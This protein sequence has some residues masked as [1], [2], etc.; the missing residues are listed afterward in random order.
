MPTRSPT[1]SDDRTLDTGCLPCVLGTRA[2][3]RHCDGSSQPAGSPPP[4][5]VWCAMFRTST[6][7]SASGMSL[8]AA[9]PNRTL[10][11]TPMLASRRTLPSGAPERSRNNASSSASKGWSRCAWSWASLSGPGWS[12]SAPSTSRLRKWNSRIA[13]VAQRQPDQLVHETK[14]CRVVGAGLRDIVQVCHRPVH[15]EMEL[16]QDVRLAREVVVQRRLGDAQWR[17]DLA[18]RGGGVPLADEQVECDLED[19]LAGGRCSARQARQA[20]STGGAAVASCARSP[21]AAA[22]V[23][24]LVAVFLAITGS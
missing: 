15:L 11:T 13:T 19:P 14:P 16:Q 22:V 23:C 1:G 9:D 7:S 18:H 24:L 2:G 8:T 6:S 4:R 17:R 3:W 20:G 5:S 21:V 12:W 10:A